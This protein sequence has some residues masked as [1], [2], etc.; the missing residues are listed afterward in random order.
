[1]KEEIHAFD[2]DHELE[3]HTLDSHCAKYQYNTLDKSGGI[4][5]TSQTGGRG[6]DLFFFKK[7]GYNK[8]ILLT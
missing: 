7:R 6:R 3:G 2:L 5:V 4:L 1:M 8:H